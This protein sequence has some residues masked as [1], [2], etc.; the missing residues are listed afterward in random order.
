MRLFVAVDLDAAV[1]ASIGTL[2]EQ[3]RHAADRAA[4]ARV[5]WAAADRVHITLHFLGETPESQVSPLAAA[6][7][8]PLK[9][10]AF[11][12]ALGG[13]GTFPPRGRPRVLWLGV[14]EGAG[15][16][17]KVH[18]ELGRRLAALGIAVDPRPFAAHVTLARF[19]EP[20]P[21]SIR[22]AIER[23]DA[24]HV[25]AC[26]VREVTLYHSRLGRAGATYTPLATGA[27]SKDGR[28]I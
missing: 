22:D 24:G 9:I 18:V 11:N 7:S 15:A 25:G 10:G 26:R 12:L 4:K 6:V 21:L 14:R 8:Q 23:V 28:A 1:R 19:R 20:A 16:L 13:L 17:G 3:L 27:L 5:T 2:M